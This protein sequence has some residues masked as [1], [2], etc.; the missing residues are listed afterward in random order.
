MYIKVERREKTTR[1]LAHSYG[2][3]SADQHIQ[4]LLSG[5]RQGNAEAQKQLMQLYAPAVFKLIVRMT[6]NALDAEELTQDAMLSTITHIQDYQPT[7]SALQT[8]INRIAYR[9]AL[10][11]LRGHSA[12]IVSLDEYPSIGIQADEKTI[13]SFFQKADDSMTEL[14]RQA[15]NHL[16]P[17][18]QTL[19]N[20]FYY[21]E[22]PLKEIAFITEAPPGTIATRLHRIRKR[23]YNI[24]LKLQ[25][26]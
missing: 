11:H 26:Q 1:V 16:P 22:L 6:H 7:Q 19:V 3:T 12:D 24:I 15:L 8:W 17:D 5:L 13:N 9:K 23:L 18:E 14:L 21:D 20:L 25:R 10:N 4:Q 2:S